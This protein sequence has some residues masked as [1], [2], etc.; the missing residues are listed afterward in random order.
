MPPVSNGGAADRIGYGPCAG[1]DGLGVFRPANRRRGARGAEGLRG[2]TR[3]P[4]AV[5]ETAGGGAGRSSSQQGPSSCQA[6]HSPVLPGFSF[7]VHHLAFQVW[8]P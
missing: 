3:L 4:P 6:P 7:C 1:P 5:W 2:V 8:P